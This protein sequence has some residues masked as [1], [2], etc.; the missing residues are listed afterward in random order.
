MTDATFLPFCTASAPFCS[1]ISLFC[2]ILRARR[3]TGGQKSSWTS[4]T[5]NAVF[6][7]AGKARALMWR[8]WV[9]CEWEKKQQPGGAGF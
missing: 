3:R 1:L 7:I 8:E 4:T 6:S 2:H 5:I 9:I